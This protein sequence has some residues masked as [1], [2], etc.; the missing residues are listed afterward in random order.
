M[1]VLESDPELVLVRSR[2][3]H[4][5]R[6]EVSRVRPAAERVS[7]AAARSEAL[8]PA[9]P[10]PVGPAAAAR[11][12]S[13]RGIPRP[14]R[15]AATA[16]SFA[17][18]GVGAI[19]LAY[20]LVPLHAARAASRSEAELRVQRSVHRAYRF[21]IR[22]M[23]RLGLCRTQ[24]IGLER[25][26]APGAKLVVANHPTLIDAPHVVAVLPQADCV[27]SEDWVGN[28][29]LARTARAAGYFDA[30]DGARV[31]GL[32]AERLRAGRTVLFFPE[33]TRSPE[34]GLRQIRRGAAHA[35]IA[36]GVPIVPVVIQCQPRTLMKGQPF[37]DV[38]DRTP[39]YTL[40]VLEPIDPRDVMTPGISPS[41][42][43][44]RMTA[45]LT[46]RLAE[47]GA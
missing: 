17:A 35:A 27:V 22:F 14:L 31:V 46:A 36:A 23:E 42:A 11:Q 21:F 24:W 32:C 3:R 47:S 19:G 8:A 7:D 25:L 28:P 45:L 39:Q 16:L 30:A 9:S 40:R 18:Y 37:W 26:H 1:R 5:T 38:P 33:G 13:G 44:R 29:F 4:D 12:A 43:A 34:H 10:A 20:V 2:E 41:I 15:I 6:R